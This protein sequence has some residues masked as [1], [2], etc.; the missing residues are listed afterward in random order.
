LIWLLMIRRRRQN[1]MDQ[2]VAEEVAKQ[3]GGP[4]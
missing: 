4:G 2:Q 3:T 1:K